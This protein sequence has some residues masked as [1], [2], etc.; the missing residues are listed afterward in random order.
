MKHQHLDVFRRMCFFFQPSWSKSRKSKKD[1]WYANTQMLRRLCWMYAIAIPSKQAVCWTDFKT[2]S[3]NLWENDGWKT[4]MPS[5]IGS[6]ENFQGELL[7]FA[8]ET[9]ICRAK[10]I[11]TSLQHECVGT[12]TFRLNRNPFKF[13]SRGATAGQDLSKDTAY[14]FCSPLFIQLSDVHPA[15]SLHNQNQL[16]TDFL[17][18]LLYTSL[19]LSECYPNQFCQLKIGRR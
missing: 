10:N 11:T 15:Q 18:C 4:E 12:C 16:P 14:T 1:R 5:K 7:D 17:W 13:F 3:Q 6:G 2:N 19:H 8:G 9:S